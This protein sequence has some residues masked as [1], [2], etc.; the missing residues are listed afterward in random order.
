MKKLTAE[1]IKP[2]EIYKVDTAVTGRITARVFIRENDPVFP[3]EISA[4]RFGVKL[5]E[6]SK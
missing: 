5:E 2:G 6:I 1:E 3:F 4:A